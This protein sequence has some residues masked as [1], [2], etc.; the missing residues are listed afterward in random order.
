MW[1]FYRSHKVTTTSYEGSDDEEKLK[2]IPLI[3]KNNNNNVVSDSNSDND[4]NNDK[5]N[6]FDEVIDNEVKATPHAM[7]KLQ[8]SYNDNVNKIV[9]QLQKKKVPLNS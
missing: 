4:N 9:K 6:L 3:N 8:A 2:T 5:E 1:L 7:K